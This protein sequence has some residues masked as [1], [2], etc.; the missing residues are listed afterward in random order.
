[1]AS[2]REERSRAP[3]RAASAR[4]L[5]NQTKA[6]PDGHYSNLKTSTHQPKISLSRLA[7]RIGAGPS[8]AVPTSPCL[9]TH[10][11]YCFAVVLPLDSQASFGWEAAT[12]TSSQIL[13]SRGIA[14][15]RS[16]KRSTGPSQPPTPEE[17]AQGTM[18]LVTLISSGNIAQSGREADVEMLSEDIRTGYER[19][20][21]GKH[22]RC[23]R[24][25][26]R[27]LTES[28]RHAR[29]A[30]LDEDPDRDCAA[31]IPSPGPW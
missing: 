12:K 26:Q 14:G 5:P 13:V 27:V 17:R 18:A 1:M 31:N 3:N 16:R 25:L 24:L 10:R 8:T 29:Q 9:L 4:K 11:L 21:G 20:F 23:A 6:G 28:A 15:T 7:L 30:E 19:D 22:E 2:T